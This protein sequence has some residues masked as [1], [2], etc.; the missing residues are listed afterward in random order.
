M[1]LG[2]SIYRKRIPYRTNNTL[3][4]KMLES[5]RRELGPDTVDDIMWNLMDSVNSRMIQP[6]KI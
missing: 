4:L 3:R 5:A 6:R 1:N 2:E